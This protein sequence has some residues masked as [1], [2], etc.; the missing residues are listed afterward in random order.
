SFDEAVR[1]F[2]AIAADASSPWR[3]YGH[4]L[5]ARALIRAGTI[6][7]TLQTKPLALAEEELRQVLADP[8]AS[9]LPQSARSL[10]DFVASHV[11]PVERL[12]DLGRTLISSGSVSDRQLDDYQWL[13]DHTLGD[14]TQ[15]AYAGIT[16]REAIAGSSDVND[17][18]IAMQGSGDEAG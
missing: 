2:R 7:E 5:A 3:P 8:A 16:E 10:H 18:I 14:T 15:Y 6:P 1:R 4:Y 9:T 12:R 17:W 11:R 13:M